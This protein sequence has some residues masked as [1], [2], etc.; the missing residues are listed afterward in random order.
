MPTP[1]L[2]AGQQYYRYMYLLTGDV[3]T[4]CGR[5]EV[6]LPITATNNS[7]PLRM[8]YPYV[9]GIYGYTYLL[10]HARITY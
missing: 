10:V 9:E 6:L 2:W 4:Y 8:V 1:I 3:Y 7:I 5:M